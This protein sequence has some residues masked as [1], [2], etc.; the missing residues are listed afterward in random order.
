MK[1][2]RC[3]LYSREKDNANVWVP[4]GRYHFRNCIQKIHICLSQILSSKFFVFSTLIFLIFISLEFLNVAIYTILLLIFIFLFLCFLMKEFNWMFSLIQWI[5]SSLLLTCVFY[6]NYYIFHLI[7]SFYDSCSILVVF[8][9][10]NIYH[11]IFKLLVV[12]SSSSASNGIHFFFWG[13]FQ[14]SNCSDLSPNSPGVWVITLGWFTGQGSK[15]RMSSFKM[16]KGQTLGQSSRYH[17]TTCI[18][19]IQYH[20]TKLYFKA[21]PLNPV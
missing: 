3:S 16:G 15:T 21:L 6:F 7:Y 11:A 18:V 12:F 10:F 20:L 9:L 14:V 5:E 17:K 2:T 13:S 19:P 4:G 8:Y 1:V